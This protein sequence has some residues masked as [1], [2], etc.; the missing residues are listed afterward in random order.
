MVAYVMCHRTANLKL[1][2]ASRPLRDDGEVQVFGRLEDAQYE[3]RRLN[4]AVTTERKRGR[5][6]CERYRCGS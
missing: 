3:A 2:P 5:D 1:G 4:S 6:K